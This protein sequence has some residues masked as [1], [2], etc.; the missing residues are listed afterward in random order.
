MIISN[1]A[2]REA[3]GLEVQATNNIGNADILKK[4]AK[5][6]GISSLLGGVVGGIGSAFSGGLFSGGSG[7]GL[8]T[9]T[10]AALGGN[11]RLNY[12]QATV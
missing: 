2:A 7:N 4:N 9:G 12:N 11:A 8:G 5:T 10:N 6:T 3:Y 1:N